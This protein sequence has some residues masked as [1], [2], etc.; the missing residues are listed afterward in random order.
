MS[1][2]ALPPEKLDRAEELER[3]QLAGRVLTFEERRELAALKDEARALQYPPE[4]EV[5]AAYLAA[6]KQKCKEEFEAFLENQAL[7]YGKEIIPLL[8]MHLPD[9]IKSVR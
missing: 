2:R 8:L 4:S 5:A 1:L 7:K 3:C 9:L 6:M